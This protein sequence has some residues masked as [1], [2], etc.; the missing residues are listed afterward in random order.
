MDSESRGT[1]SRF[2][3]VSRTVFKCVFI[4]MST[5]VIV[6]LMMVPFLSSIVTLSLLSFI[7]KRTS[8]MMANNFFTLGREVTKRSFFLYEGNENTEM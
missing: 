6:P 3:M 1:G 8:F 2:R 5:P 4:D 7:K